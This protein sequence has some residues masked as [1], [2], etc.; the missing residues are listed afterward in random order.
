[1][2]ISKLNLLS[3][4]LL[5]TFSTAGLAI[6]HEHK[7]WNEIVSKYVTEKDGQTYFE[8]KKLKNDRL[9]NKVF[10]KYLQ[11][12]SSVSE[13]DYMKLKRDQKFAFLVNAYNAFTVKLILDNYPL[14]SIKDIGGLFSSP[15]KIE[16]FT[17][18][19]EKRNL[20]YIEHTILRKKFE[21]PRVHFA[22][23]CASMG[24]PN[25]QKIAFTAKNLEK[26]LTKG[27]TDFF[28]QKSKNRIDKESKTVYVSKI[29]NWFGED[30]EK[31]YGTL[32]MYL[33]K[34]FKVDEINSKEY[35][36]K[37]TEYSWDLNEL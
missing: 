35:S 9:Q 19:G 13:K 30:F 17:L 20:D 22:V 33:A 31:K 1:M 2:I 34:V 29:F 3:M 27:E 11:E 15:W 4:F 16:F 7:A 24:C 10:E 23:N 18:L 12:L 5:F 26:L 6:D 28:R 32:K 8:Y 14:D 36:V 25:I 21:E 37:F